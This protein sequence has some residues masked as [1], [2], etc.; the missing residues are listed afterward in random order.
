[1]PS[2]LLADD[3]DWVLESYLSAK[4]LVAASV[5]VIHSVGLKSSGILLWSPNVKVSPQ[6]GNSSG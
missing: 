4:K 3:L 5:V 1:V 6:L 2:I